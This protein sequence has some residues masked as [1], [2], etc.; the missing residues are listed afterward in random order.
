MPDPERPKPD[1]ESSSNG[2]DLLEDYQVGKDVQSGESEKTRRITN[3]ASVEA[4]QANRP[5]SVPT[6]RTVSRTSFW[7]TDEVAGQDADVMARVLAGRRERDEEATVAITRARRSS[8]TDDEH[9]LERIRVCQRQEIADHL[10]LEAARR[11]PTAEA[12]TPLQRVL[13]EAAD[14]FLALGICPDHLEYLPDAGKFCSW[15]GKIY[16]H[17]QIF[18]MKDT[19]GVDIYRFGASPHGPST[20]CYS[21]RERRW[22][23]HQ[24]VPPN[25]HL[26]PVVRLLP[27]PRRHVDTSLRFSAQRP[28]CALMAEGEMT[29]YVVHNAVYTA[30]QLIAAHHLHSGTSP[31]D[32]FMEQA[33]AARERAS[34]MAKDTRKAVDQSAASVGE[35]VIG[36]IGTATDSVTSALTKTT[37]FFR[38]R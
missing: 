31:L 7:R 19:R 12:E 3:E 38:R 27:V 22:R 9:R 18:A 6:T 24:A 13:R 30:S 29:L 10:Q 35:R 15:G 36:A 32:K 8:E 28:G 20:A 14:M 26:T 21:P 25:E 1:E 34:T 11:R 5:D 17:S 33:E 16:D 4:T 37:R 2:W 23:L